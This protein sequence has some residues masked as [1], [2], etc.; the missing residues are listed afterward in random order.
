M[1]GAFNKNENEAVL[2]GE[3]EDIIYNINP[4]SN[5]VDK[6]N[7]IWFFSLKD[8]C[9]T[10]PATPITI[11]PDDK[12]ARIATSIENILS[13]SNFAITSTSIRFYPNPFTKGIN[14]GIDSPQKDVVSIAVINS[15]GSVMFT[16]KVDVEA[17]QNVKYLNEFEQLPSGVYTV[18]LKSDLMDHTTRVIRIE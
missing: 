18:K 4:D 5:S 6:C 17:G 3:S 15:I 7:Y 13:N 8:T 14:L 16:S 12:N 11:R 10:C 1:N 2:F 9:S